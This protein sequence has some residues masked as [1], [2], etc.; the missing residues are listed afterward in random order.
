MKIVLLLFENIIDW[1]L[2]NQRNTNKREGLSS[3]FD[4]Q[5]IL[6]WFHL[7]GQEQDHGFRDYGL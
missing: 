7:L 1:D 2:Q 4:N 5:S 6:K 3:C